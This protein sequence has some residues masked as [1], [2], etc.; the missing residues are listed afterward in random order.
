MANQRQCASMGKPAM[1]P[2]PPSEAMTP[3]P[4]TT[5]RAAGSGL[6]SLENVF[7]DTSQ[8]GGWRLFVQQ[9]ADELGIGK[10]QKCLEC[11]LISIRRLLVVIIEISQQ[12]I[13]QLPHSAPALPSELAQ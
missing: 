5:R 4:M 9:V 3:V 1:A 2:M 8:F 11:L 10:R 13:V 6:R 7:D 12:Q